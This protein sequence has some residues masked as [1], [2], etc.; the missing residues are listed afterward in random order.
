[1][2]EDQEVLERIAVSYEARLGG[3]S[4]Q[5][6]RQVDELF[7]RYFDG[8]VRPLAEALACGAAV[9]ALWSGGSFDP[10]RLDAQQREA[11]N[12]AFPNLSVEDVSDYS[13]GALTGL[14]NA[15]KGKLFEIKVRDSLN[16]GEW[17]GNWHLEAGQRAV[18]ADSPTQV[19]WDLAIY[20][21]DGAI[22]EQIQLKS[23]DLI[24]HVEA[25]AE[26]YPEIPIVATAEVGSASSATTDI[27]I[28]DISNSALEEGLSDATAA[29]LL[30][31]GWGVVLPGLPLA[32][33]LY[34]VAK[35]DRT[36]EQATRAVAAS[37][38]AIGTAA[39]ATD[40]LS[41]I[42]TEVV[43]N[44]V[45]GFGVGFLARKLFGWLLSGDGEVQRVPEKPVN[46]E[47]LI[48]RIDRATEN[49]RTVSRS[50]SA[51]PAPSS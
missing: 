40:L 48:L 36:P 17:V 4:A 39:V 44:G 25:A 12:L 23:T 34:W 14:L 46:W 41:D 31:S 27:S 16:D 5:R 37:A 15:W 19:G 29:S 18:L 26:R 21:S 49:V 33:N 13:G 6:R 30:D 1:M 51:L 3:T 11:F 8:R 42:A 47:A 43:L 22:A 38:A 9:S 45:V 20:G 35:G 24:A 7:Q 2:K 28:S 32:L 10:E 50:Y